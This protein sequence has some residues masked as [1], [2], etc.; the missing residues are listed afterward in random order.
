MI[1]DH[2]PVAGAM[3]ELAAAFELEVSN[4]FAREVEGDEVLTGPIVYRRSDGSLLDH[5]ITN[6][7]TVSERVDSVVTFTGSAFRGAGPLEPLMVFRAGAVSLEPDRAWEFTEGT[8]RVPL[9]GWLQ[10]GVRPYG[11]GRVALI[12]EAGMFFALLASMAEERAGEECEEPCW[13]EQASQNPRFLLNLVRWLAR[14][15]D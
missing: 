1:S 14:E 5:S 15:L 6:G 12:G 4:G 7:R 2:M 10:G 3:Q 9:E 11:R 8:R 13:L